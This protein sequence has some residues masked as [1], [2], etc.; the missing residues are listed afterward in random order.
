MFYQV[1]RNFHRIITIH[2]PAPK[3]AASAA[4]TSVCH[5]FGVLSV[6]GLSSSP[7]N[8]QDGSGYVCTKGEQDV[9]AAYVGPDGQSGPRENAS[10][11]VVP[12][13]TED[14]TPRRYILVDVL[15]TRYRL[16][17]SDVNR[18]MSD[19]V[20][21][22][23]FHQ[24]SLVRT[25]DMLSLEGV[26]KQSFI[27]YPWLITLEKMR[28]QDKLALVQTLQLRDINDFVPFLR[29]SVPRLRKLVSI[30]NRESKI[31]SQGNRIYYISELLK[32]DPKIVTKYLSKRLFILEMPFDMLEQN[33]QHMINYNVSPINILKDL[34]AFRYT[35]K[36]VQLRLERAKRA[37]KDKIMPWMVRCPEPIL[38]RSFKLTLDEL[39]VL[40]E[41]KNVVEY[42]AERLQFDIESMRCIMERHP[43]V[44][45]VRVTKVKEV[46][47]YLLNEA[48]FTRHE[49]ANVPRILCHGLETTK[50]RIEELKSYGCRP[51]SLVIVCRS[52]REYDKFV[53]SWLETNLKMRKY[54]KD[55]QHKEPEET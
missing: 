28:L 27:N 54:K 30:M 4:L 8:A 43:A 17:D 9:D 32:V 19:E 38:Q 41:K 26:T 15:R 7:A 23:T 14:E 39:A 35:P 5:K 44:M 25:L 11:Y 40:G 16:S 31:L 24:R 3:Y 51:S 36:S 1:L 33:L 21:K 45:R 49:I 12:Y 52:K 47:D 13:S 18:I 55:D 2:T 10:S 50:Q 6:C 20:V 48:G 22:R 34:W 29:L 42:V 46:L 53:K 37:K